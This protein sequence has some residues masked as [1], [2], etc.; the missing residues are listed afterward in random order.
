M[1]EEIVLLH[2]I[3]TAFSGALKNLTRYSQENNRIDGP[4]NAH[5]LS[6]NRTQ[7]ITL[8]IHKN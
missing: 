7:N 5:I 6:E 3:E 8:T 1:G 4:I 2:D